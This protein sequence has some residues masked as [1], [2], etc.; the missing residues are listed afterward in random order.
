MFAYLQVAYLPVI[1]MSTMLVLIFFLLYRILSQLNKLSKLQIEFQKQQT[2]MNQATKMAKLQPDD[3]DVYKIDLSRLLEQSKME[4][5]EICSDLNDE[6]KEMKKLRLDFCNESI[7]HQPDTKNSAPDYQASLLSYLQQNFGIN[8]TTIMQ[9]I[10]L[11][12]DSLEDIIIL[13]DHVINIAMLTDFTYMSENRKFD[14]CSIISDYLSRY[15]VGI[16]TPRLGQEYDAIDMSVI[17][18]LS[19]STKVTSTIYFGIAFAGK[20]ILKAD[21]NVG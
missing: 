18:Q 7:A 20:T 9:R 14:F 8:H 6:L 19:D 12:N 13:K 10:I 5:K 15:S 2:L 1:V 3:I 17:K 4:F 16:F 21:V 11:L